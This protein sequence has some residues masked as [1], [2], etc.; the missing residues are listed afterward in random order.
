MKL[1]STIRIHGIEYDSLLNGDGLRAVIWFAG[2]N[3]RCP[4][5]HNPQTWDPASGR[6]MDWDDL[7]E[8]VNY[9]EKTYSS[10]VT[11]SGGDP[12]YPTNRT[13]AAGIA[14]FVKLNYPKKTVWI[15]TGYKWEEIYSM[16]YM[17]DD[18]ADILT[19]CDVI[20]DGP[21][22]RELADVNYPWAGST[23]QRVIDVRKTMK[24]YGTNKKIYLWEDGTHETPINVMPAPSCC[25]L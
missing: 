24:H 15:Y 1:S 14:Q 7:S 11:L 23:N 13:G 6:D 2:C 16:A 5:C 8:L 10:G 20:V 12:L 22:I 4:G 25:D 17:D 18:V 9:L 3:H 21:F 19:I